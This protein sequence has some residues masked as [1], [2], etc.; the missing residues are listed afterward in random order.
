ML[1]NA[2]IAITEENNRLF[3]DR[4]VT[5]Q[6]VAI[7]TGFMNLGSAV[8]LLARRGWLKL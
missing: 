5:E 4:L 6:G 7:S 2:I 3:P 1:G 8:L